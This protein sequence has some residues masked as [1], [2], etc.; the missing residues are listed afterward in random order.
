MQDKEK[1]LKKQLL[2]LHVSYNKYLNDLL[3]EK[4]GISALYYLREI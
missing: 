2:D 4:T 1:E 3:K